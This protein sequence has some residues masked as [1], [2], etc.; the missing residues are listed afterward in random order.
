MLELK[1]RQDVKDA[2][3][4]ARSAIMFGEADCIH[5]DIVKRCIEEVE[6]QYPLIT[7]SHAM[8]GI[9][10]ADVLHFPTIVFYEKGYE[11]GRLVGSGKIH[12]IKKMLNIWFDK[13]V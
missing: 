5:C 4:C 2:M 12:L 13:E 11:T 8:Q 9:E 3:N 7:F 1:T 6:C 10:P